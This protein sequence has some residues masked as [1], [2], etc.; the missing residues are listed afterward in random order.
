VAK[1]WKINNIVY[2]FIFIFSLFIKL[3]SNALASCAR[4]REFESQAGQIL[5]SE[6]FT[7]TLT[8]FTQVAIMS[9]ANWL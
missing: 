5:H 9:P 3:P 4:G 2:G 7:S 8:A 6:Q 1:I